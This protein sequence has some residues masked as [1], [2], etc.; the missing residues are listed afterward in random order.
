MYKNKALTKVQTVA[1]VTCADLADITNG[2]VAYSGTTPHQSGDVATYVC[3]TGYVA[4]HSISRVCGSNGL[5]PVGVWSGTVASC[6]GK[7]VEMFVHN[8]LA[9]CIFS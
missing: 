4:S 1:V 5:S 2:Y 3:D 7:D 6:D 8:Q 9:T